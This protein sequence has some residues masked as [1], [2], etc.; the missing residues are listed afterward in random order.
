MQRALSAV[1]GTMGVS[2]GNINP[3]GTAA[4]ILGFFLW[5]IP[6]LILIVYL[7]KPELKALM[8]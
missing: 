4:I 2:L 6:T 5:I 3:L 8:K 1:I 7:R